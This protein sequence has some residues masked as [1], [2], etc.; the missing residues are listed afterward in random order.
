MMTTHI[1]L[2]LRR[3][4]D[5]SITTTPIGGQP[6]TCHSPCNLTSEVVVGVGDRGV[7]IQH[8]M[9]SSM[10]VRALMATVTASTTIIGY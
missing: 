8:S 7:S 10:A 4:M 6:G 2:Y 3:T 5:V 1:V 9:A